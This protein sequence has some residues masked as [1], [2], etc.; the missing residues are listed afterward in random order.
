MRQVRSGAT[1]CDASIVAKITWQLCVFLVFGS[2]AL[3]EHEKN[4]SAHINTQ[5]R[6]EIK[7]GVGDGLFLEKSIYLR[8][9][10][11]GSFDRNVRR[12]FG[13]NGVLHHTRCQTGGIT[14]VIWTN[15]LSAEMQSLE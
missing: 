2:S 1:P 9:R 6:G 10:S 7:Q 13:G 14:A 3:F 15:E 5:T 8:A 4:R 11:E 12:M